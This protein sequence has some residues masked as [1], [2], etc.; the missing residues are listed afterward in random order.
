MVTG[1]NHLQINVPTDSLE[2][3]R[4]FYVGF[5]GMKEVHRPQV[6]KMPGIWLNAGSFE[7]HI[8]VE[9]GVDRNKTRAHTAFEVKNLAEFRTKIEA[10]GWK[11]VEQPKIP[12]YIRFHFRDPF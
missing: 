5:L 4:A 11:I 8:G 3:A 10:N 2:A 7:V 12:N 9:D 6:F 1:V